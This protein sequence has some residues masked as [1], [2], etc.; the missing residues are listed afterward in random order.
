[1]KFFL[2]DSG[3][4]SVGI[5]PRTWTIEITRSPDPEFEPDS[6][7]D[8]LKTALRD[9]LCP[10]GS[11]FTEPEWEAEA[12]AGWPDASE[13]AE[14]EAEIEPDAGSYEYYQHIKDRKLP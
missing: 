11:A 14:P 13:L 10:D 6:E 8:A 5:F 1:M 3:D 2:H 4:P 12:K 7:I 9:A